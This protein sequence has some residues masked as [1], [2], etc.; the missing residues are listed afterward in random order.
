MKN[1]VEKKLIA[2]L[3]TSD[4]MPDSHILDAAKEEMKKKQVSTKRLS[5]YKFAFVCCVVIVFCLTIV[6][7]VVLLKNKSENK[8]QTIEY[9]SIQKYF[10]ETGILLVAF[11]ETSSMIEEENQ[12]YNRKG[13]KVIKQGETTLFV[14]ETYIY[15]DKSITLNV[16]V[17][18]TENVKREHFSEYNDFNNI[19]MVSK[20]YSFYYCFNKEE[21]IGFAFTEYHGYTI[22]FKIQCEKEQEMFKHFINFIGLQKN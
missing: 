19:Y 21:K 9:T 8:V 16:V 6:L 13:C 18:N 2:A 22:Y 12:V 10:D 1:N 17:G 11:S 5:P 15:G 14:Q 20:N 7:S 4:Q 3:E